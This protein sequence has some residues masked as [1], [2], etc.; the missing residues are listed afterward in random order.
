[1][2]GVVASKNSLATSSP[3]STRLLSGHVVA[4]R[5]HCFSLLDHSLAKTSASRCITEATSLLLRSEISSLRF[6]KQRHGL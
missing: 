1:M 6:G 4:A 2:L 5:S 3:F